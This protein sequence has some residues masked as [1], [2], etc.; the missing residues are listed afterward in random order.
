LDPLRKTGLKQEEF[1]GALYRNKGLDHRKNELVKTYQ[2]IFAR[3]RIA[4]L[5][6]AM[7]TTGLAL[8]GNQ[9]WTS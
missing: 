5:G 8:P 3:T 7:A 6:F 2:G 9:A 4:T 1:E